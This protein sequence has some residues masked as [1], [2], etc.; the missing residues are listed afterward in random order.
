VGDAGPALAAWA[1]A[2]LALSRWLDA[3]LPGRPATIAT[4]LAAYGLAAL[5]LVLPGFSSSRSVLMASL[6]MNAILFFYVAY[7]RATPSRWRGRIGHAFVA[8]AIVLGAATSPLLAFQSVAGAAAVFL[9][10][11]L[12]ERSLAPH[13]GF[14]ALATAATLLAALRL[15]GSVQMMPLGLLAVVLLCVSVLLLGLEGRNPR[16]RLTLAWAIAAAAPALLVELARGH[17]VPLMLLPIWLGFTL[18]LEFWDRPATAAVRPDEPEDPWLVTGAYLVADAAG[19]AWLVGEVLRR[20]LGAGGAAVALAL[21]AAGHIAVGEWLARWRPERFVPGA[22]RA[23]GVAFAVAALVLAALS[24][25]PGREALAA[26]GLVGILFLVLRSWWRRRWVEHVAAIAFVEAAWVA[27]RIWGVTLR[28]FYLM[29]LAVYLYFVLHRRLPA[30]EEAPSAGLHALTSWAGA[31]DW[32]R[33]SRRDAVPVAILALTV[34]YPFWALLRSGDAVHVFFLGAA[35]LAVLYGFLRGPEHALFRG[36]SCGLLLAG[37]GGLVALGEV[38]AAAAG[39]LIAIGLL[40]VANLNG[41][42]A[43]ARLPG[44]RVER[45]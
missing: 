24:R 29:L 30:K 2:H 39:F 10:R 11:S 4:G 19:A 40:M 45:G 3:K 9:W 22:A 35:T 42:R 33:G 21:W 31:G 13:V 41:G 37:A 38:S 32:L 1:W 15:L 27:G 12:R 7:P 5:S 43:A 36:L 44:D 16:S 14:L 18:G 28:D 6:L 25:E 17:L 20:G 26:C 23:S 8:A 34:V